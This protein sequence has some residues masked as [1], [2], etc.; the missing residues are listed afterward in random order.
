MDQLIMSNKHQTHAEI[1]N[2]K[3][4]SAVWL[5]PIL[6]LAIGVWMLYQFMSSAG[7]EI[8]LKM[9]DASGIEVG[10]TEIKSLNVKV[11]VVTDVKLSKEYDHIMVTASIDKDAE[12]MLKE[13]TLFWVVKPRIDKGGIS[14]LGTLLSGA[15]IEIQPGKQK[16]AKLNFTVLDVPPIAP[17]EAKGLRIVLQHNQ[18]GKLSVG[19]P[20]IYH[21][22]TAGR[23]E[24]INYDIKINKAHYQAFIYQPYDELI[25][26][27]T[28]FWIGSGLDLQLNAQGIEVRVDS[29]ESLLGGG[30]TFGVPE[31]EDSGEPITTQMTSFPLFNSLK[32]VEDGRYNQYIEYVMLFDESLRGLNI[33][34]PVEYRGLHI[35]SVAKVLL[36]HPNFSEMSDDKDAG[37]ISRELPVL[38]KIEPNRIFSKNEGFSNEEFIRVL[39]SEFRQGLKARLETGSLLTGA[40][41]IDLDYDT[42]HNKSF[43]K[44][45]YEGYPV[46]PTRSSNLTKVEE[47]ITLLLNNM[48]KIPFDKTVNSINQTLDTLDKTLLS[49]EQ[50]MKSI[51]TLMEQDAT[52]KMPSELI[53][54]LEQIQHTLDGFSPNST[55]YQNLDDALVEFEE[56]MQKLQPVLNKINEKPNALV[57]GEDYVEDPLPK[58]GHK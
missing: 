39:N 46:F 55:V 29:L 42:T 5:I 32:E 2:Q 28:R 17:P 1:T 54:S 25:R 16:K 45:T 38:I 30:V 34:A 35:G 15:Y 53:K 56:M 3:A 52:Q 14:G 33:G 36:A 18:A 24:S 48:S 13:D 49:T 12:R 11:G 37:I 7:P 50:S 31:G 23:I 43:N 44:K 47:Q 20:V 51:Q 19:D 27:G 22:F 9:S 8:T 41:Y 58:K 10:K 6:A 21:G 26:T 4:I 40:L 57:F